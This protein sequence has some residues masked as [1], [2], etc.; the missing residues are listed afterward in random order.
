MKLGAR[1]G[2]VQAKAKRIE[3]DQRAQGLGMRSDVVSA[4]GRMSYFLDEAEN[5][6]KSGNAAA[7]K[8]ALQRADRETDTL[9]RILGI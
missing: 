7:A 4:L 5:A 3:Q 6:I 1:A 2:A 9:E 8:T